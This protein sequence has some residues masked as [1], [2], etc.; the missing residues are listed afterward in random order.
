MVK[1]RLKG[2]DEVG[3]WMWKVEIERNMKLLEKE[4]DGKIELFHKWANYWSW[5]IYIMVSQ[6]TNGIYSHILKF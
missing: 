4:N 5:I 2:K 1:S 3:Q 6:R